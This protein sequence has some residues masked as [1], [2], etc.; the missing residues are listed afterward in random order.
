MARITQSLEEAIARLPAKDCGLCGA[1][2]CALFA[3]IVRANP[4]ELKRCVFL[5]GHMA[6]PAAPAEREC[7]H[8]DMLGRE[9]DFVLEKPAG[10][11][12]PRETILPF[13]PANVERLGIKKGD[14]LMGRPAAPGCPVTH[15]GVVISEPDYFN[16]LV[17]WMVVGPMEARRKGIDIGLYTPVAYEGLA[18]S[19]RVELK[20]G[21]RY[22]FLPKY[23]MLGVRHWGLMN[24][25]TRTSQGL[26]VRLEG[27][28]LA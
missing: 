18:V 16:G 7:S 23:C 27:I 19:A 10:D 25:L 3:D 11:I 9:Y 14:T 2:T 22:F 28:M 13:N 8:L 24:F 6:P 12:G 21:M 4:E 1:R 15:C 5:A 20:F 17:E 26:Y